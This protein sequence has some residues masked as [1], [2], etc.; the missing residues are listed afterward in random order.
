MLQEISVAVIAFCMLLITIGIVAILLTLWRAVKALKD[1]LEEFR[2]EFRPLATRIGETVERARQVTEGTLEQVEG[3]NASMASVRDKADRLG[4]LFDVLEE[5]L[6]KATLRLFSLVS[7]L[8]RF[9]RTLFR[10]RPGE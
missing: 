6:E 3:F 7:G 5:D 1:L 9:L 2:N 10:G 4:V 8:G